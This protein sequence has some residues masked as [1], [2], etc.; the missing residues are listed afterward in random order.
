MPWSLSGWLSTGAQGQSKH[1]LIYSTHEKGDKC[2]ELTFY[3]QSRQRGQRR[4]FSFPE[5]STMSNLF[6]IVHSGW[7]IVPILH[8]VNFSASKYMRGG[9][10]DSVINNQEFVYVDI[11]QWYFAV[12]IKGASTSRLQICK[13]KCIHLPITRSYWSDLPLT[14]C[15]V[16]F[17]VLKSRSNWIFGSEGVAIRSI[18]VY[19]FWGLLSTRS[20]LFCFCF[21]S[22]GNSRF[23]YRLRCASLMRERD[24]APQIDNFSNL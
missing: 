5:G 15:I 20:E 22:W 19:T 1:E 14:S 3:C 16:I 8:Q 17:A 21:G 13:F 11:L 6:S 2:L 7:R 4:A 12:K 24:R 23:S 18:R 10:W 9:C